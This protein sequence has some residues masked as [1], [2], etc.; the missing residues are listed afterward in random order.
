[1]KLSRYCKLSSVAAAS[2]AVLMSTVTVAA[3]QGWYI[4][5]EAVYTDEIDERFSD[6][7]FGGA[8]GAGYRYSDNLAF[9]GTVIANEFG[10]S[11]PGGPE[12]S[13]VGLRLAANYYLVKGQFEP[14]ISLGLGGVQAD[15]TGG[16]REEDDTYGTADLG[17]GVDWNLTDAGTG[18]R[19]GVRYRVSFADIDT[20]INGVAVEEDPAET[21]FVLGAKFALG[22][23][24]PPPLPVTDSDGDGVKDDVDACPGTKAGQTVDA[25]GC[26][27]DSDGDK[28]PDGLDKCPNTPRGVPVDWTGCVRVT[29]GDKDG[30]PDKRDQCPNTKPGVKV[31]TNG[32]SMPETK[33]LGGVLFK[34]KSFQLTASAKRELD[35]LARQYLV[36]MKQYKPLKLQVSGHTDSVAS[37]T[38]NQKLSQKRANAVVKYLVAK[39]IDKARIISIGFGEKKPVATNKTDAG[40]AQNRRVEIK[41]LGR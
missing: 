34:Y 20:G 37:D 18:I 33:T 16:T 36:L 17:V 4:P 10:E 3:D 11:F 41:L 9:E 35:E 14:F 27:L 25:K 39:G 8:L 29:D 31:Y 15:L 28:V 30:V 38:Y 12:F 24:A 6:P 13:E 19:A 40:R 5:V 22:E 7:G 1:M 23:S 21:Q 26:I 2:A 32:C